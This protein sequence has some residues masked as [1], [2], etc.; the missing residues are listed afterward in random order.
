ME[1]GG[2]GEPVGRWRPRD[3]S[4]TPSLAEEFESERIGG[5]DFGR[6]K[7]DFWGAGALVV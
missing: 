2:A 5:E 3:T 6:Y 7:E 1:A 4:E